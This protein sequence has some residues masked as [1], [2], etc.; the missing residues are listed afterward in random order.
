MKIEQTTP[1]FKPISLVVETARE[2][3][4]LAALL[5][6]LTENEDSKLGISSYDTFKALKDAAGDAEYR[7]VDDAI[8]GTLGVPNSITA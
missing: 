3:A 1:A 7:K 8:K 4:Y 5:S 6:K 2:A